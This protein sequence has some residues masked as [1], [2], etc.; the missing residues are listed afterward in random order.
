MQTG[1]RSACQLAR[2][3]AERLECAGVPEPVAS[4]SIAQ[5]HRAHLADGRRVAV[6]V[7][8]PGIRSLI[9]ADLAA[10]EGIF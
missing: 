1:A 6:K 7:Q 8:Y 4:A 2:D 9:E 5:V 3:A 10:L